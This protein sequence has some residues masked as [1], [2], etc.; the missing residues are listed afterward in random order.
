[1]SLIRLTRAARN[2]VNEPA[3]YEITVNT[4]RVM[5]IEDYDGP[6]EGES[7]IWLDN[8][9][10]IVVMESQDEIRDGVIDSKQEE[11]AGAG[12]GRSFL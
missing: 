5:Y 9:R 4:M 7:R 11:T 6:D 1:M 3:S 8:G 10:Q 2:S 12:G